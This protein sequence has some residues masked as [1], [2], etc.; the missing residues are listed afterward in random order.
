V[1]K[2]ETQTTLQ[3]TAA[4]RMAR[5]IDAALPLIND[6]WRRF[7]YAE[8]PGDDEVM[9]ELRFA[10]AEYWKIRRKRIDPGVQR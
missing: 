8:Q 3:H 7:P 5:A 9:T 1:H 2:P 4:D 10:A 6:M